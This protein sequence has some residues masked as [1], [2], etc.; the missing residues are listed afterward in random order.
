L[1]ATNVEMGNIV[2]CDGW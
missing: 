1:D 2:V